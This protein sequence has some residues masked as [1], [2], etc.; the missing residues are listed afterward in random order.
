MRDRLSAVE[1]MLPY[2][3]RM[4]DAMSEA[5]MVIDRGG[6]V[7]AANQALA[8][9]LDLPDKRSAL[10]PLEEYDQLI[11]GWQVGEEPFAPDDL[12]RSLQGETISRQLATITTSAGRERIIES[13][14][15]PIRDE[16][17]QVIM[18]MMVA[19]DI[20]DEQRLRGYWRAVGMAA[21]GLSTSLD[22]NEVLESVLDQMVAVLGAEV[23]IAIWRMEEEQ[24]RLRLLA[25]RGLS[26]K[27]LDKLRSLPVDCGSFICE[28]A[29]TR[30]THYIEDLR[31]NPPSHEMDRRLA[32]DEK[33]ISWL[34]GPL[35]SGGRLI[36]VV[37]YWA[38]VPRR[39]YEEDRRAIEVVNG[40]FAVAIDHAFLYQESWRA[41]R[42]AER[43]KSQLAAVL[44]NLAEGVTL[45]DPTGRIA[46]VN[47]A[48]REMLGLPE[49]VEEWTLEES[50]RLDIRRLDGTPLPT[51]ER[52]LDRAL[53]GERFAR[54]EVL[55][56]RSDGSERRIV[57]SGSALRDDE[58]KVSLAAVAYHDVTELRQLEQTREEYVSLISHDLRGPL[59]P[60]MGQAQLLARVLTDR[61]LDREAAAAEAIS[62]NAR[63]MNSMIQDL[64]E[65]A[66]L[67]TGR[68]E[69]RR[70]P[71]DLVQ[72][73]L[74]LID[75]VGTAEDRARLRVDIPAW[76][77]PVLADSD[78]I[79]R[80][81]VN[82]LTNAFKYSQPGTP[83]TVH[84]EQIDGEA[85]V[86]VT[87]QGSGI[88]P[89]E[90]PHLFQR[91]Y[92]A[93]TR[94]KAEGLGLGLYISRLIVE[95]HGGRIWAQSEVGKGSTFTFTLPIARA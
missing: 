3:N 69:L 80:V 53:R 9:L 24:G 38:H 86:S 58:G 40:L 65:S 88:P 50:H 25:W 54:Q 89:E 11:Q 77:P 45:A 27:T 17:G 22:V 14:A 32:R 83:I 62:K 71:T 15:T 44:E 75:R 90:L 7:V 4:I 95:A 51:D 94:K 84:V 47:R 37:A 46:M 74:D 8:A 19:Q 5:V 73:V 82:L 68:L 79:E 36:G 55:L 16:Q 2:L 59:T 28:A 20:T 64:L 56:V 12:R 78:R 52:P 70:E 43:A 91:S 92:R 10:R 6:R 26:E 63:R 85:Q 1:E 81:L 93:T 21:Q 33:L 39:F 18:A 76:V 31:E 35:L 13:T 34:T 42:E 23:V 66:R 72:L 29:R 67:E 30:E 41:H 87:D 48:G 49:Q 61:G 57:F 60:I